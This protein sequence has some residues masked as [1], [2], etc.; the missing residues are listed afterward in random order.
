MYLTAHDYEQVKQYRDVIRN[1][2]EGRA[3]RD[4]APALLMAEIK[5]KRTGDG[6][7]LQCGSCA[8]QLFMEFWEMILIYESAGI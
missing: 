1:V 6:V 2:A 5:K 4:S 7:N 8:R 3:T